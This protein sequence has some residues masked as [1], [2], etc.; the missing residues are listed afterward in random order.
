MY[1][2]VEELHLI[3]LPGQEIRQLSLNFFHCER[4][5]ALHLR[6]LYSQ[7]YNVLVS[8]MLKSYQN[9]PPIFTLIC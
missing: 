6:S 4:W 1:V 2:H 8:D 5:T 3:I 7:T 9:I